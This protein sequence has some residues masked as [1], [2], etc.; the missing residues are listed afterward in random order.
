MTAIFSYGEWV[1]ICEHG[2][3]GDQIDDILASWKAD[4][5]K[6]I[7]LLAILKYRIAGLEAIERQYAADYRIRL[8]NDLMEWVFSLPEYTSNDMGFMEVVKD[9]YARLHKTIDELNELECES[10]PKH[11]RLALPSGF[12]DD[13]KGEI[14]RHYIFNEKL[15][16]VPYGTYRETGCYSTFEVN[17]NFNKI[18][19]N[20]Y[21]KLCKEIECD[22]NEISAYESDD[23]VAMWVWDGDGTLLAWVKDE[24][25][26][27][28][29]TD[30]KK[31][32]GWYT[33][34]IN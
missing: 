21:P 24:P 5:D 30:C 32:Y 18:D 33:V 17:S 19:P 15:V 11:T 1:N 27:L 34:N 14:L 2:T 28:C 20:K 3:N 12:S 25:Y 10:T 9:I 6:Y 7:E 13:E 23:V 26:A 4:I 22:N 29:N 16:D 8:A 31:N